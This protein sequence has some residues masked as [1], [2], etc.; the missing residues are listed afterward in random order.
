MFL[1][2][3]P[4]FSQSFFEPAR[5]ISFSLRSIAVLSLTIC[6]YAFLPHPVFSSQEL[7][8]IQEILEEARE[9]ALTIPDIDFRRS[10]LGILVELQADAGDFPAALQS[11]KLIGDEHQTVLILQ[12]IATVQIEKGDIAGARSTAAA[13][14]DDYHK[15]VVFGHMAENQ[16]KH[17]DTREALTTADAIKNPA[18]R[19]EALQGI[20][21]AQAEAGRF[22]D[23]LKTVSAI[24][25][26]KAKAWA[27]QLIGVGQAE[28][29]KIQDAETTIAIIEDPGAHARI[30][31]AFASGKAKSGDVKAARE[32]ASKISSPALKDWAIQLIAVAQA[33]RGDTQG[34]V[35]TASSLED[36]AWKTDTYCKIAETETALGHGTSARQTLQEGVQI[37]ASVTSSIKP[38][39]LLDLAAV[40]ARAGAIENA[41][42]TL[43]MIGK[44]AEWKDNGLGRIVNAQAEAEDIQGALSTVDEMKGMGAKGTAFLSIAIARVKS[45]ELQAVKI[46]A[47]T[48]ESPLLRT[49]ILLGIARG[50]LEQNH[51]GVESK[52]ASRF[53]EC[54]SLSLLQDLP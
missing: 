8:G 37:A 41:K 23:A 42:H 38:N 29:G 22:S 16:A 47:R 43:D 50:K 31:A 17:G 52:S 5:Y 36:P 18:H 25:D 28:R 32:I 30:L 24:R 20:V 19:D 14:K 21:T 11:A 46:W 27:L 51:S 33:K 7:A 3:L 48:Q 40:Q 13:I 44:D 4:T 9:T 34:A 15:A 54:F 6:L 49:P 2:H 12:N 39:I 26:P 10:A 1:V 53:S 35:E 45:G